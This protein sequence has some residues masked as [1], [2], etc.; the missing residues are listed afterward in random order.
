M[1]AS[2]CDW[3]VGNEDGMPEADLCKVFGFRIL[4]QKQLEAP[5]I[6]AGGKLDV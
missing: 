2:Q 6:S 4:F 3:E 5:E 1:K